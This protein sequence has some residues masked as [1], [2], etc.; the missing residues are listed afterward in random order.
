MYFTVMLMQPAISLLYVRSQRSL[1]RRVQRS[2]IIDHRSC[3]DVGLD[4]RVT[5]LRNPLLRNH[6][7]LAARR[8][9]QGIAL[10]LYVCLHTIYDQISERVRPVSL[11]V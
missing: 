5:L 2:S 7:E 3:K 11:C 8:V 6:F 9:L 1:V 10:H 4:K